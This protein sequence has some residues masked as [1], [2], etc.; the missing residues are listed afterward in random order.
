MPLQDGNYGDIACGERL[1]AAVEFYFEDAPTLAE[2]RT[3]AAQHEGGSTY[4]VVGC[5]TIVESDAWVIDI[6]IP[7]F[8][9]SA[10]PKGLS[11][12]DCVAGKATLGVDPFFYFERLGQRV[13]MPPLIYIWRIFEILRQTAPYIPAGPRVMIRDPSKLGWAP[14]QRTDAW[15]D[16]A[17]RADYLLRCELLPEPPR[18]SRA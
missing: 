13:S 12:G 14:L 3:P 16:D 2:E 7:V 15:N 11:V 18:R 8:W 9:E 4:E 5:V 17:G 6:G 10:P 1:D